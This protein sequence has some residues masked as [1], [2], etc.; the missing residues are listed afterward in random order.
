MSALAWAAGAV[1][2]AFAIDRAACAME[3]RGWIYWRHRKPKGGAIIIDPI[4]TALN[5]AHSHV[6][7]E[8]ERTETAGA[9]F[10]DGRDV[11]VGT[12]RASCDTVGDQVEGG[13]R[14]PKLLPPLVPAPGPNSRPCHTYR[15]RDASNTTL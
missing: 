14:Q 7:E 11:G 8:R 5:P 9:S 6:V 10:E 12:A 13:R 1:L 4:A 2:A 3:A 15:D